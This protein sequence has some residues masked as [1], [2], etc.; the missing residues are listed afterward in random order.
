[1]GDEAAAALL[2]Q[3]TT[4]AKSSHFQIWEHPE[5]YSMSSDD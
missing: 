1:M 2:Q 4:A 3:F 5:E